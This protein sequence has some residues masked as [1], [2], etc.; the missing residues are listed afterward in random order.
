MET[1]RVTLK[2]VQCDS[3]VGSFVVTLKPSSLSFPCHSFV[4]LNLFQNQCDT[5]T[6]SV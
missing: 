6:S 2:Q 3:Q 4:I 1:V 5:E